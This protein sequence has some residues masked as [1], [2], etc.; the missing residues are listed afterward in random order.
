[1]PCQIGMTH[2]EM[3]P[4]VQSLPDPAVDSKYFANET[5]LFQRGLIVVSAL[6]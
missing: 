5:V 2:P 1:M 6:F 4:L 3:N